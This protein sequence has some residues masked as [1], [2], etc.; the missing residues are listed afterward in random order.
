MGDA[1]AQAERNDPKPA[2]VEPPMRTDAPPVAELLATI[3][4]LE[5]D[6]ARLRARHQVAPPPEWMAIKRAADRAGISY[7]GMRLWVHRK[8]VD[9][10]RDGGSIFVNTASLDERLRQIGR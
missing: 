5:A 9:S 1:M 8:L 6:N 7:E 4:A 10:R 2:P 3:A